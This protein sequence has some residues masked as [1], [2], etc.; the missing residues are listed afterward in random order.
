[1]KCHLDVFTKKYE[2]CAV[3]RARREEFWMF[4]LFNAIAGI[5]LIAIDNAG[6]LTK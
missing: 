2:I 4:V 1:M 6:V 5:V 3:F